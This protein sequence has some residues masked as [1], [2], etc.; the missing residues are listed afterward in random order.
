MNHKPKPNKQRAHDDQI[1]VDQMINKFY[2][3]S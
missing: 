3:E 2:L 1:Y